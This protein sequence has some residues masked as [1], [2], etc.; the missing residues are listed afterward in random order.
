MTEKNVAISESEAS[1]GVVKSMYTFSA[2]F[3]EVKSFLVLINNCV[4]Q[5]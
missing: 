2:V 1:I 5:I 4:D 3:A